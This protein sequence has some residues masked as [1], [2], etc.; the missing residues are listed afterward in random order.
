MAD[1]TGFLANAENH[2]LWGT[3]FFAGEAEQIHD[4]A[5]PG[6]VRVTV[7]AMGGRARMYVFSDN[8]NGIIDLYLAPGDAPYG[9][10]LPVRV[11]PNGTGSDVLFTLARTPGQP[12]AAWEEGLASMRSELEKLKALM[13]ENASQ[14]Q[15]ES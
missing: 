7:P 6:E 5:F 2:P 1:V 8:E 13:E 11:I 12:H 3:E 9:D 14:T 4:A 15:G 10:P